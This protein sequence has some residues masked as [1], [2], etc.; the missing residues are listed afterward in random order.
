MPFIVATDPAAPVW[1][2]NV[3]RSIAQAPLWPVL[4][5]LNILLSIVYYRKDGRV[6]MGHCLSTRRNNDRLTRLP[7]EILLSITSYM[8]PHE[9]LSFS[10]ASILFWSSSIVPPL[11]PRRVPIEQH[12]AQELQRTVLRSTRNRLVRDGSI[13]PSLKR[14]EVHLNGIASI[15]SEKLIPGTSLFICAIGS[16]EMSTCQLVLVDLHIGKVVSQ[17]KLAEELSDCVIGVKAYSNVSFDIAVMGR[18][19]SQERLYLWQIFSTVVSQGNGA[20]INA[21]IVCEAQGS[22]D[23]GEDEFL[24]EIKITKEMLIFQKCHI[25]GHWQLCGLFRRRQP[26][27]VVLLRDEAVSPLSEKEMR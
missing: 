15:N 27:N 7:E 24:R 5:L 22:L 21:D 4:F 23:A 25:N 3:A 2:W 16:S 12:S 18:V 19:V 8:G 11:L 26:T 6:D 17:V 13:G 10:S 1:P 14:V 9:L 20:D